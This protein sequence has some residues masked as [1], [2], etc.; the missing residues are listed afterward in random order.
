MEEE[1][2]IEGFQ[3]QR[4]GAAVQDKTRMLKVTVQ[5]KD[6]RNKIAKKSPVLKTKEPLKK[7]F[8]NLDTNPTYLKENKRLRKAAWEMKQKPGFEEGTGR[9]QLT[10]NEL[11]VDNITIDKNTFFC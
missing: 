3:I 6:I 11:K 5:T 7:I 2:D 8:I 9:V 1:A 4:M 10:N